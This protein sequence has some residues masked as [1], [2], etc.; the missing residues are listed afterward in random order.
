[1]KRML[2]LALVL[3]GLPRPAD[4]QT[5]NPLRVAFSGLTF[6]S[7]VDLQAPPDGTDRLFVVEQAGL[8]RAFANDAGA[9]AAAPFLDLRSIVVSGGELGLLGLAFHPAYATNGLFFVYYTRNGPGGGAPYQSVVARYRV[10]SNPAAADAASGTI[11]FTV[12]QPF[13]N[14]KAGQLQFGPDGYLYV[15][16]GDGGSGGDPQNNGQKLTTLLGKILRVDV[17]GGGLAPDCGGNPGP[18]TIPAGNAFA[19]ATAGCG[20]IYAYGLRNP[21]RFSF[22]AGRLWAADVGQGAWEEIDWVVSGGNYG[23]RVREGAHCY[24]AATCATAGLID[25]VHEYGHDAAGGFSVTG[26]Y[27]Q[28]AGG[29]AA[30]E[31]RYVFAD[32]VSRNVW[33]LAFD[34]NGA[35]NVARI[36][37]GADGG[38][39]NISTFGLDANGRMLAAGLS[40]GRLYEFDCGAVLPVELAAFDA[41]TDGA[42]VR[43]AWATASETNNAGFYVEVRGSG[44]EVREEE[45]APSRTSDLAPRTFW[46]LGFVPGAGTTREAARYR[47]ATEPLPPGRYTFRLRQVDFDGAAS[48]SAEV[49]VS[50]G[51]GPLALERTSADP[52]TAHS[53]FRLT[54]DRPQR[55]RAEAFDALGRRVALLFD[56]EAAPDAPVVLR[57]EGAGLAPGVYVVRARGESGAATAMAVRA[58]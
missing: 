29:C 56:G 57:L 33:A 36:V 45:A 37:D 30:L 31:G 10:S 12:D 1:M 24:N 9:S 23:W 50:V 18:Y 51:G 27:V 16:L 14:H 32:Y 38:A 21:F 8:I 28:P 35:T 20:E 47:F 13:G 22:G 25:P 43:L 7:P 17:D 34:G 19:G 4:A 46:T 49:E 5:Q 3:A 6:A 11:L 44:S 41:A 15:A 48:H 2:L 54:V 26:G 39:V 53:A 58:R 42:R 40:T 52:F 55:V